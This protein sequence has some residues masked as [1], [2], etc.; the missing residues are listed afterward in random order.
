[1]RAT[2]VVDTQLRRA[3]RL[4]LR[5]FNGAPIVGAKAVVD[6]A[7]QAK[8]SVATLTRARWKLGLRSVK[9]HLGW[10]WVRQSR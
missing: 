8:I 1:L 7:T 9:T 5:E 2:V 4:I 6:A 3:M 10:S